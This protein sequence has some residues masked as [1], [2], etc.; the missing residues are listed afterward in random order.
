DGTVRIGLQQGALGGAAARGGVCGGGLGPAD[1]GVGGFACPTVVETAQHV[2]FEEGLHP[3][4]D[5]EA[6][7]GVELVLVD[8]AFDAVI[9]GGDDG[10]EVVLQQQLRVLF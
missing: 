6:G 4:R 10:Q 2:G 8:R 9:D 1:Q 5:G 7:Q 3:D